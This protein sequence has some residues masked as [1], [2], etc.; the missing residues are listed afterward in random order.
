MS[1]QNGFVF[2]CPQMTQIFADFSF[3]VF[4]LRSS[5]QSADRNSGGGE[6]G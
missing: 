4:N 3:L 1:P 5:A 6:G 2:V